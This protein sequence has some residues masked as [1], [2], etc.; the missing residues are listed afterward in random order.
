MKTRAK[1]YACKIGTIPSLVVLCGNYVLTT[2]KVVKVR[3]AKH[4]STPFKVRITHFRGSDGYFFAE[5]A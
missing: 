3:D 2:G 1:V 4:G 5:K